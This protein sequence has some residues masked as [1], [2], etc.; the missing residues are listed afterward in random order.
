MKLF[1]DREK[2]G[3][4][5]MYLLQT[6]KSHSTILRCL[7]V[8]YKNAFIKFWKAVYKHQHLFIRSNPLLWIN[9]NPV[10]HLNT[11]TIKGCIFRLFQEAWMWN[12]L[13][14]YSTPQFIF[15]GTVNYKYA[16]TALLTEFFESLI[17]LTLAVLC[18]RD[19]LIENIVTQISV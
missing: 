14:S 18:H 6:Q 9:V 13:F 10:S 2:N 19:I 5:H 3:S 11:S 16:K 8:F 12:D 15:T 1:I 4:M 7:T 17:N